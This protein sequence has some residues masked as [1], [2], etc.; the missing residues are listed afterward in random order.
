[1]LHLFHL[2]LT[3]IRR[4]LFCRQLRLIMLQCQKLNHNQ[5][6]LKDELKSKLSKT[7]LKKPS[8]SHLTLMQNKRDGKP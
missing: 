6:H 4:E 5:R 3:R 7:G 8:L 1:M 2:T